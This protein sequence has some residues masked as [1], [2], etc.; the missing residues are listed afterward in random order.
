MGLREAGG[1]SAHGMGL[2]QALFFWKHRASL[3]HEKDVHASFASN[4][5]V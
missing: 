4:V 2:Q 3:C 1:C 5:F